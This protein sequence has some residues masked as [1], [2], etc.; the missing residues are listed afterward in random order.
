M[1]GKRAPHRLIDPA[2]AREI[3]SLDR[4]SDCAVDD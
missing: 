1:F 2:V 3:K 4:R